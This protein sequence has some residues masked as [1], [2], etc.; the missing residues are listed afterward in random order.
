MKLCQYQISNATTKK[1]RNVIG[2]FWCLTSDRTNIFLDFKTLNY[3]RWIIVIIILKESCFRRTA[4]CWRECRRWKSDEGRTACVVCALFQNAFCVWYRDLWLG[5]GAK[6]LYS[7][8]LFPADLPNRR[9]ARQ[10]CNP[11][12]RWCPCTSP[13]GPEVRLKEHSMNSLII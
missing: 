9:P 10:R 1:H 2:Y 3:T 5:R 4:G 12:P 8:R 6:G 7:V 11:D 13:F